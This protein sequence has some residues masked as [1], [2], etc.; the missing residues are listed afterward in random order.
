[1]VKKFLPIL[2]LT[3]AFTS[4]SLKAFSF[5]LSSINPYVFI[6]QYLEKRKRVKET[7]TVIESKDPN[8]LKK[9]IEEHKNDAEFL[10]RTTLDTAYLHAVKIGSIPLATIALNNGADINA[11]GDNQ[12]SAL[13]YAAYADNLEM[14]RFLTNKGILYQKDSTGLTPA[15]IMKSRNGKNQEEITSLLKTYALESVDRIA[16]ASEKQ[17]R[18]LQQQE[19]LTNDL[20]AQASQ[21]NLDRKK[22]NQE[23]LDL[24]Q[25]KK[26]LS[27][28][29]QQQQQLVKDKET[30][31]R[32]NKRINGLQA[33]QQKRKQELDKIEQ[34]IAEKQKNNEKNKT[35][36]EQERKNLQ[37]LIE[38]KN[39][40]K[41]E[42]DKLDQALKQQVNEAR[43]YAQE[44]LKHAPQR[45]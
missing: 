25:T 39:R 45:S 44:I 15:A 40:L 5:D 35:T 36:L 11:Q 29:K 16:Q 37:S 7:K 4:S 27:A 26:E 14:V 9:F 2:L 1:M 28:V 38:Q 31:E 32:E 10:K 17:Q 21:L 20:K 8:K 3:V 24:Q 43:R 22:L 23:V 13:H 6:S 33:E 30:L 19:K 34:E 41:A 42:L 12:A 18:A